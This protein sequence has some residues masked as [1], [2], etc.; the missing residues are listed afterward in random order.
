[1]LEKVILNIELY[2]FRE[3]KNNQFLAF[4]VYNAN[5]YLFKGN[6]KNVLYSL[7]SGQQI[8]KCDIEKKYLD[9][10]VEKK[11]IVLLEN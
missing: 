2:K 5:M 10:L 7:Y 4:N 9:F 3:E 6:I 8:K 11:I 1:M